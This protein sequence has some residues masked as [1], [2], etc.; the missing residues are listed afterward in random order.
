[1]IILLLLI[2]IVAIVIFSKKEVKFERET[3]DTGNGVFITGILATGIII[4]IC[5]ILGL[6]SIQNIVESNYIPQEINMY[7]Q[8]NNKIE[9]NINVV[10]SNYLQHENKVFDKSKVKESSVMLVQTYPELKSNTIVE[11]QI[12]V[13]YSNN[14]KIKKLKDEYIKS[15]V[16][17]WFLYFNL[18]GKVNA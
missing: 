10:V 7:Q 3:S 2:A 8:E 6:C 11:E 17:R 1:M 14:N 13:Y 15:N 5:T 4:L 18:W 12:K 16:S 9:S